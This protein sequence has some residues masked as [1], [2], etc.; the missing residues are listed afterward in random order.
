MLSAN[1]IGIIFIAVAVGAF[2]LRLVAIRRPQHRTAVNVA[3]L[4]MFTLL[5]LVIGL[6]AWSVVGAYVGGLPD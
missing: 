2:V 1:A 4:V 6:L 5:A 3:T